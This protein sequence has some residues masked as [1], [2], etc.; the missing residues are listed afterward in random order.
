MPEI[1]I[2]ARNEFRAIPVNG[3]P[4]RPI[5][6]ITGEVY[7]RDNPSCNGYIANKL[8]KLGAEI[9]ITPI[10]EWITYSTYRY[11]RDSSW[12]RNIKG[13]IKS[14]IQWMYQ[15]SIEKR[16]IGLVKDDI[17]TFRDIELEKCLELC[18]PYIDKSY[19]GQPAILLGSH[20]GQVKT[21]I[22]GIVN[23]MPFTCMPETFTTSV[24]PIFRKDFNN[25]P[26]INI[27]YDGQEDTS[28]DTK[29]QALM[30]QAKKYAQS[31]QNS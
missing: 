1:L 16:F 9:L 14:K 23:I 19:D 27:A 26:W 8:E 31:M 15:H 20:A 11:W 21:G 18:S 10:R 17:D 30:Y 28:I 4:R 7:M 22:S 24:A 6:S 29:L 5:I 12:S 25:I 13:L 3:I 2:R